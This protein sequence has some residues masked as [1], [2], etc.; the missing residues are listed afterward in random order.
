MNSLGK[1]TL[2]ACAVASALGSSAAF[3]VAPA[4]TPGDT[5]YAGGGSAQANA[6]FVA[7][8]KLFTAG[9]V[10]VYSDAGSALSGDMYVMYGTLAAATGGEAAGTNVAYLYKFNG[11]SFTNGIAP[12]LAAS[13][14]QLPYPTDAV[15]RGGATAI[16]GRTQGSSCTSGLP[17]Y[18]YTAGATANQTPDFGLADVEVSM[19]QGYNNPTGNAGG[20]A[21]NTN[22]GVA[23]SVGVPD[24][25]YDNLFGVAVTDCVYTG[26]T[27]SGQPACP[28]AGQ[29]KT[30]FTRA[31]VEGILAG[32]ISDWSQLYDD[33]GH[34]LPAG[35][36]IFSDR[37]EGSGTKASGNQYFLGYPGN[38]AAAV[39]PF[40][41]TT[42][43]C[44]TSLTACEAGSSPFVESSFDIATSSTNNVIADLLLAQKNGVRAIAILGLENPPAKNLL[45]AGGANQY[46][47]AKINGIAVDSGATG[48]NIN[49][50]TA[51]SYSNVINGNY[52][53]FYQNSF[54]T[55]S[56]LST[57]AAGFS[58]AE[59]AQM[60]KV[61]FVGCN[62]GAGFPAA[63]PGTLIDADNGPSTL[64]KGETTDSRFK[65]SPAALQPAILA[66]SGG[67]PVCSDPI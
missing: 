52:D 12:Q 27:Q 21:P 28:N 6:F 64:A 50:P 66:G 35:G 62:A 7:T 60:T 39:L 36:I 30:S 19:F 29:K 53:F 58:A 20:S 48:D 41:A 13:P 61:T 65:H 2:I 63:L 37:G 51:T 10:D 1:K 42:G 17:T 47:F 9:T 32:N 45:V 15:W 33:T 40:S 26:A 31:E 11:G 67:I 3:A 44:G 25:I 55:R 59:K 22:G 8:C 4:T 43:Y 56:S 49:G 23:P 57:A 54:N 38:G 34:Q 14:T 46:D 18:S 5:R 16:A 24:A